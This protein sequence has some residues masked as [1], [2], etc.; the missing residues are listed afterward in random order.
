LQILDVGCG[1]TKRGTI[2]VDLNREVRPDVVAEAMALPFKE[3]A[4]DVVTSIQCLEHLWDPPAQ[5]MAATMLALE[6]FARVLRDQGK[7]N[8]VV[9]NFAGISTLIK[10]LTLRG[11]G[12]I[13][14]NGPEGYYLLGSHTDI[15]QVHHLLFTPRNLRKALERASFRDIRFLKG[16]INSNLLDKIRILIPKSRHD[17]IRV[18]ARKRTI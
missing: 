9:P 12:M 4:F 10:W 6:E 11:E 15:Y 16:V 3:G 2:G 8:L 1:R 18:E 17:L 7:L 13:G 14:G 5:P